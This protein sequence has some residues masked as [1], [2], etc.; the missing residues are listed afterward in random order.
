M[1]V[2][3]VEV[4]VAEALQ[5]GCCSWSMAAAGEVVVVAEHCDLVAVGAPP[6]T[7]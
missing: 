5:R 6:S 7:W 1:A 3:G 4:V 2:A